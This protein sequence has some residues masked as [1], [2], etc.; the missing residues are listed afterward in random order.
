MRASFAA[1]VLACAS[2]GRAEFA[3]TFSANPAS[4]LHTKAI[5]AAAIRATFS[6]LLTWAHTDGT[7]ANQMATLGLLDSSLTN[8]ET[9][10]VNVAT[11]LADSFGDA[12]SITRVRF[13]AISADAGNLGTFSVGGASANTFTNWVVNAD[14]RIVLRP[15][16]LALFVAPDL[17]GYAIGAANSLQLLNLSTNAAGFVLY[18]GGSQ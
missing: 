3:G 14:D 2:L 9:R 1:V 13:L 12:I 6:P 15:G 7:N 17:P 16:G 8:S 18:V 4:W 11:G 5:G 10:A